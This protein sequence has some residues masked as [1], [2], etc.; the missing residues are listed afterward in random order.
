M[1]PKK[2][3]KKSHLPIKETP[4]ELKNLLKTVKNKEQ[5]EKIQALYWLQTEQ[6]LRW[7]TLLKL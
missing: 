5:L 1:L 2:M 3:K 4:E 7:W 6:F